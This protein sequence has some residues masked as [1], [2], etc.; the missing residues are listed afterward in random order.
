MT[1][2]LYCL[3]GAAWEMTMPAS[4]SRAVVALLEAEWHAAH[5]G[6]GHGA[7]TRDVAARV[8][9]RAD[10]AVAQRTE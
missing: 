1:L 3:C 7:T 6:Y 2:A 4:T 8:R 5:Q 9:R 10:A